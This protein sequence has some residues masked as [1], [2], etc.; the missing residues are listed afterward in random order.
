MRLKIDY[1]TNSSS[2]SFTLPRKYLT[3]KQIILIFNHIEVAD[4]ID[5]IENP[6]YKLLDYSGPSDEWLL[7]IDEEYIYGHTS[8]TNFDMMDFFKHIG[9][10]QNMVEYKHDNDY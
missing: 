9:I 1:I 5:E 3:E 7:D 6:K 10:H 8:M 2:A 4:I